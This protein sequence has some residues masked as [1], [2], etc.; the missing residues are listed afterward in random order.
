MH[1]RARK[2]GEMDSG[3]VSR[4]GGDAVGQGNGGAVVGGGYG[5]LAVDTAGSVCEKGG[6]SCEA[7]DDEG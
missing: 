1:Q 6:V 2:A 3:V 7:V 4:L 5:V